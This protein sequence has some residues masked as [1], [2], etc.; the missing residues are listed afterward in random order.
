MV[1][2]HTNVEKLL[3][4]SHHTNVEKL[5]VVS[6]NIILKKCLIIR[7]RSNTFVTSHFCLCT[8]APYLD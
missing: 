4:V 2:H 6:H 3:M 8:Q 5:L 1:S 7:A